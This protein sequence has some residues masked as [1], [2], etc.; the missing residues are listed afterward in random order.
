MV[1][2][3]FHG[4]RG[5]TPCACDANQRYGG[6]TACV[7]IISPGS[8]PIVLDLGT[9]LR[10]FGTGQPTDRPFRAHA[11]VTHL[12]WDHV[13]GLPFFAPL[14]RPGSRLDIYG[15]PQEGLSLAEAF[16]EFMRPPYFPVR[17]ADLGGTIEFHTLVPDD[18]A[19]GDAKV[20]ARYVPHVGATF[21]YRIELGSVT[22][23]YISDHQQP[24]DGSNRVADEVLELADGVD[25]L[26]HDAQ[27]TPEE[28]VEKAHWGH[29]TV[30]YALRV[31][32][33][34][35]AR[36][37]ALFHHDPGHTDEMVDE[38]TRAAQDK[39]EALGIAEVIGAAEGLTIAF[40]PT[41]SRI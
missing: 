33:E 34:A 5:S 41:G 24:L 29:C 38:I 16:E 9:G 14:H 18:V 26:I 20:R 35:G 40:D 11:L 39:A 1:D 32:S 4:V 12:H 17:V 8:D 19:I 36:R 13:Q 25:L 27:Y 21:G 37:L 30:D 28:F 31:A 2:I 6:N 23:A 10:F 22:I 7:S 3:T 15:P